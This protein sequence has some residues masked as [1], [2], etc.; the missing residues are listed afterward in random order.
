MLCWR[1]IILCLKLF[2]SKFGEVGV[3]WWLR[4]FIWY[5]LNLKRRFGWDITVYGGLGLGADFGRQEVWAIK[6]GDW[7]RGGGQGINMS[8][9]HAASKGCNRGEIL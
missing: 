9:P 6:G 4:G 1:L 7:L 8:N 3:T 5:Q 2:R